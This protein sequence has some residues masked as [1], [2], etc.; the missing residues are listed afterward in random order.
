MLTAACA[1]TTGSHDIQPGALAAVSQSKPSPRDAHAPVVDY[2]V[3]V[4]GPY[5][6]P[7]RDEGAEVTVPKEIGFL[8]ARR[9]KLMGAGMREEELRDVYLKDAKVLNPILG[10]EGFMEDPNLITQLF[11]AYARVER[12]FVPTEVAVGGSVAYVRGRVHRGDTGKNTMT[13][14]LGLKRN[15]S[16]EWRIAAETTANLDPPRFGR[17][18]TAED[19][20]KNL[21]LAGI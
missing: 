4:L 3:H 12:R 20:V 10:W 2:H 5:A 21:D 6:L 7:I 19:V 8:L 11:N 16:G 9:A 15:S 13:L 14:L 1:G 18:M 17:L